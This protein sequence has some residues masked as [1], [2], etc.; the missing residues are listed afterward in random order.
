MNFG[1]IRSNWR[2]TVV[3]ALAL[4]SLAA[5]FQCTGSPGG[6]TISPLA[7]PPGGEVWAVAAVDSAW[8]AVGPAGTYMS[9][10]RGRR[11][12]RTGSSPDVEL[13]SH[14]EPLNIA[15]GGRNAFLNL[16]G[17]VYETDDLGRNWHPAFESN[18]QVFGFAGDLYALVPDHLLRTRDGERRWADTIIPRSGSTTPPFSAVAEVVT[19]GPHAYLSDGRRAWRSADGGQTWETV[20]GI[21]ANAPTGTPPGEG[22]GASIRA[23]Y[24]LAADTLYAL[25]SN[26]ELHRSRNLG[27]SWER[28]PGR[29]TRPGAGASRHFGTANTLWVS[30]DGITCKVQLEPLGCEPVAD[31]PQANG[32]IS[33]DRLVAATGEGIWQAAAQG[34]T[35]SSTSMGIPATLAGIAQVGKAYV[36]AAHRTLY[37][38][39]DSLKTWVPGRRFASSVHSVAAAESSVLAIAGD[40]LVSCEIR[41][42]ECEARKIA[43]ADSDTLVRAET[44]RG[45]LN[46]TNGVVRLGGRLKPSL[47]GVVLRS[48]NLGRSWRIEAF[49]GTMFVHRIWV[50]NGTVYALTESGISVLNGTEKRMQM[51]G[52]LPVTSHRTAIAIA[53]TNV[54]LGPEGGD[55][56]RFALRKDSVLVLPRL[57]A[58]GMHA[59]ADALWISSQEPG[60]AVAATRTGLFW[61]SDGGDTFVPARLGPGATP[62]RGITELTAIGSN[63]LLAVGSSGIHRLTYRMPKQS[64]VARLTKLLKDRRAQI[65]LAIILL[66]VGA[67]VLHRNAKRRGNVMQDHGVLGWL[68]RNFLG[69]LPWLGV[70]VRLMYYRHHLAAQPEVRAAGDYFF[71]LPAEGPN[72]TRFGVQDDSA[73]IEA[74]AAN[75]AAYRPVMVVAGG[76]A[77]KTTLLGRIGWLYIQNRMPE[78]WKSFRPLIVRAQDYT[79][80][81]A[82]TL[83]NALNDGYA[84]GV[85]EKSVIQFLAS[86][87]FLVLFDGASE[88][89]T[90]DREQSYN[91]L[92]K[93]AVSLDFAECRFV[94]ASRPMGATPADFPKF[95]L[96]PLTLEQIRDEILPSAEQERVLRQL[97][98]LD[99]SSITPLLLHMAMEATQ[100]G[101]PNVSDSDLYERYFRR[102]LRIDGESE[103]FQWRGWNFVLATLAGES[104]IN[105][106]QRST[107]LHHERAVQVL[108]AATIEGLPLVQNLENAY[109][110]R[111]VPS[112]ADALHR[113]RSA[114][115]LVYRKASGWHFGHDRFQEYFAAASLVRTVSENGAW[116]NLDKWSASRERT[117]EF[118]EVLRLAI[119]QGAGELLLESAANDM[120]SRWR[121]LLQSGSHHMPG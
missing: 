111:H 47:R 108:D 13:G 102:L 61:S 20:E 54:M 29:I 27:S 119:D 7:S 52:R 74:L 103:D 35:W 77:G 96:A 83:A 23:D 76:G 50:A 17:T 105:R 90:E 39:S 92:L 98:G 37:Y 95:R 104:L 94:I 97:S 60:A 69:R 106:G 110:I 48:D 89:E 25:L 58:H 65:A 40:S 4:T 53:G 81:L 45:T 10:D 68:A 93:A 67:F 34:S 78:P 57:R 118:L 113:L 56:L 80:S 18:S 86:E 1:L 43:V 36:A 84:A 73:L 31:L 101:S 24:A 116:P 32:M 79:T 87:R 49:T 11:W 55:L 59:P 21:L 114:Q 46:Y 109:K 14:P 2:T 71:G 115:I 85:D 12:T 75:S 107:G 28:F 64:L 112:S 44:R 63:E 72:D 70:R 9:L 51:I 30:G 99:E 117:E 82:Q 3:S 16:A 120:P 26:G 121:E 38:S 6:L 19:A 22:P 66:L 33:D 100:A 88:I 62:P 8:L 5:A 91:A 41:F 42:R 15:A